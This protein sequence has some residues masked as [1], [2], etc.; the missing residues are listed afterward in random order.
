MDA[1]ALKAAGWSPLPTKA[2]SREIGETFIRGERGRRSIGWLSA[3][4]TEN[5]HG[6]MV[7]G[8]AIMTFADIALGC[9]VADVSDEGFFFVTA[10]FQ[11]H[12]VAAAP[13]GVLIVCEPEVVRRTSQLVFVRGLVKA[14]DRTIGS[15]DG[16]WKVL[17][18][19]KLAKLSGK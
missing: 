8:G 14:G 1:D 13:L 19:A 15:A 12:F 2:F 16:I 17:E 3:S 7:H 4:H 5:D 18:P 11:Y 6:G 10:Q 9:A